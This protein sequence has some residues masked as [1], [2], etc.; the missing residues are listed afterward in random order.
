MV[1]ARDFGTIVSQ[2]AIS[3]AVIRRYRRADVIMVAVY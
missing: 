3:E 2:G 1:L